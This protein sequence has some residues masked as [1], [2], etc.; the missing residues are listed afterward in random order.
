MKYFI[1][2][3]LFSICTGFAFEESMPTYDMYPQDV[4]DEYSQYLREQEHLVLLSMLDSFTDKG[5]SYVVIHD[6]VDTEYPSWRYS[7]WLGYFY[8]SNSIWIFHPKLQWVYPYATHNGF[9][10]WVESIGW[11]WTSKDCY[12]FFCKES[13]DKLYLYDT[14]GDGILYCYS[15][16]ALIKL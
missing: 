9:W 1:I 3:I 7:E 11:I 10:L 14:E 15:S 2:F 4:R 6:S 16:G 12:P 8:Q 5:F 13:G